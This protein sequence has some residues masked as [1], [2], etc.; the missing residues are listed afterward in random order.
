MRG[1]E[2]GGEV[3]QAAQGVGDGHHQ[4]AGG[5]AADLF[6]SHVANVSFLGENGQRAWD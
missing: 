2:T 6:P 5:V 1:S 3:Q 4:Q